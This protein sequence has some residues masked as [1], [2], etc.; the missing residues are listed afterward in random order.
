MALYA[1]AVYHKILFVH[2]SKL[3]YIFTLFLLSVTR[4]TT[5]FS[6]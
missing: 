4:V 3:L 6:H 5:N 2:V 1:Y